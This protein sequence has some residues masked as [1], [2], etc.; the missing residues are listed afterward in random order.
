MTLTCFQVFES[1]DRWSLIAAGCFLKK[2][3]FPLQRALATAEDETLAE[4]C[5]PPI[6]TQLGFLIITLLILTQIWLLNQGKR[7]FFNTSLSS[8]LVQCWPSL[9][10]H[11]RRKSRLPGDWMNWFSFATSDTCSAS[12]LPWQLTMTTL[13]VTTTSVRNNKPAMKTQSSIILDRRDTVF[14]NHR[15]PIAGVLEMRKGHVE[16]A[17]AFF[18]VSWSERIDCYSNICV[19]HENLFPE[20]SKFEPPP[21][22]VPL[23][24]CC[25]QWKDWRS[26]G[27]PHNVVLAIIF[28]AA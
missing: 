4:V 15:L 16:Q 12:D 27:L 3:T 19:S 20:C 17:R 21:I 28:V 6:L 24:L 2:K 18:Q 9:P 1:N 26:A 14:E 11:R 5:F 7:N 22:W 13:R 8:G 10:W 25:A 23:Q